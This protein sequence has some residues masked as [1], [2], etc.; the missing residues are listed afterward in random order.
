MQNQK[1]A[2]M[3]VLPNDTEGLRPLIEKLQPED[4][5]KAKSLIQKKKLRLIMPKFQ[6]D[7]TSRSEAMLKSIG[8]S[9]LFTRQESDLSLLSADNDL[10]VDEVVQ[11]VSVRVDESGSRENALTASDTQ[12]RT[13]AALEIDS[14]EVNRPFLY[15]VMDCEE[16]FVI[17]A[18]KVYTPELKED[19]PISIEV[20]FEQ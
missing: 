18:G 1:Y 11:F 17:A 20:E 14:I 6:V 15:F 12:A 7:E 16:E 10:H 9:K 13:A 19:P 8:L 4:I 3:I 5:K 2:M